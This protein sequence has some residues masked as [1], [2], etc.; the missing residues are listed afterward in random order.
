MI[1]NTGKGDISCNSK[2]ELAKIIKCGSAFCGGGPR[3]MYMAVI[4][5]F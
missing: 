4:W 5:R 2:E 3:Y 1:I